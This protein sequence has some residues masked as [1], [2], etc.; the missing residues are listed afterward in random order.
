MIK[1]QLVF[2]HFSCNLVVCSL[3]P[4]SVS[5]GLRSSRLIAWLDT[6]FTF[7]AHG[8]ASNSFG[9]C[10]DF[11][12]CPVLL[13]SVCLSLFV[14]PCTP[15]ATGPCTPDF[16]GASFLVSSCTKCLFPCSFDAVLCG[17]PSSLIGVSSGARLI[18]PRNLRNVSDAHTRRC[19]ACKGAAKTCLIASSYRKGLMTEFIGKIT[20]ENM[21]Y[22]DEALI[23]SKE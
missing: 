7:D 21:L 9:V 1:F 19:K 8:S 16:I 3:K 14:G 17:C 10:F 6:S 2:Q 15:K 12:Y 4:S 18:I 20:M 13:N 5:F 11:C 22:Q 23:T